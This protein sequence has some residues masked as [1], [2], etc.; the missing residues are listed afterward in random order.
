MIIL[1]LSSLFLS[2]RCSL[3]VSFFLNFFFFFGVSNVGSSL[4]DHSM[5][6]SQEVEVGELNGVRDSSHG[7]SFKSFM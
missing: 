2:I 7:I 6:P 3:K 5:S 1:P 4:F